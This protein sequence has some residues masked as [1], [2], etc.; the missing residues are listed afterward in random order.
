[1]SRPLRIEYPGAWYHVMNR[2]RRK[3]TVFI[4]DSDYRL[5][6]KVLEQSCML[7]GIEVHAYSLLS[8]HYH[9]LVHTPLGNLS[10]A[11]RH[12]DGVYTQKYNKRHNIDG[13]IFRGR[14]KS[15]LIDKDNY[16][17]ELVRYIHRNAFNA[18]LSGIGQYAWDSHREYIGLQ[19]KLAWLKTDE[20]LGML[21]QDENKAVQE[22]DNFVKRTI[23]DGIRDTL[24]SVK[25]PAVLGESAFKDKIKQLLK[26]KDIDVKEV[27][28]A[29]LYKALPKADI[30]AN[31]EITEKILSQEK[32]ALQS[33]RS[34]KLVKKRQALTYLLRQ[35]GNSLKD[36]G[37]FMGNIS[38][39]SVSRQYKKAE[40]DIR[41]KQ[42]CYKE[43]LEL[44]KSLKLQV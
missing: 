28:E 20:V 6:L 17:L 24:D 19:A 36:I 42:G 5:F 30:T 16:L 44:A 41:G 27:K 2:G 32:Q 14:Y 33:A 18:G 23:P 40:S 7:Y 34:R 9:L 38:Y 25:W 31:K 37:R 22:F 29:S 4:N 15:I 21:S 39:V 10:K 12:I 43:V 3:E 35:C 26:D 8:N 11:I 1:M 13:G